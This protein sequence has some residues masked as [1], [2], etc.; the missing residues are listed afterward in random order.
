MSIFVRLTTTTARTATHARPLN[1]AKISHTMSAPKKQ[2]T[3]EYVLYYVSPKPGHSLRTCRIDTDGALV[4]W[5][6]R[7]R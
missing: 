4:A 3:D 2:R 5:N 1:T 6:P 7:T